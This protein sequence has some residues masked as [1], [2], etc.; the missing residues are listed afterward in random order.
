M[1]APELSIITAPDRQANFARWR[2]RSRLVRILRVALPA[3]VLLILAALV[4][5]I[6]YNA[7]TAAPTQP[8]DTSAPIT[9]VSPRFSGRDDKGRPFVITALSATRDPRQFQRVLLDHPVLDMGPPEPLHA[10]SHKGV[11]T[12][13]DSKLYLSGAVHVVEPRGVFDT[14]TSVLDTKTG[15]VNGSDPVHGL[16][17]LGEIRSKSYA[18]Y[19]KGE[20]MVFMGNVFT[21]LNIKK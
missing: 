17:Y 20:Q 2:R 9:L 8:R 14:A 4:A 13:N 6:I 12:E 7:L 21:R 18:V 10:T 5:A 19:G 1:S 11:Y 16:G 3:L 15:Q